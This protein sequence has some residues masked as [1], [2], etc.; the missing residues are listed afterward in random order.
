MSKEFQLKESDVK[1]TAV[2]SQGPGGQHVNKVSSAI[3]LR[4]D[5]LASG[6]SDSIKQRIL[7]SG[8]SRITK[9]G[10]LVMKVQESRSQDMNRLLAWSRLD[11]WVTSYSKEERIRRA[12]RPK[13]GAIE[14]RLKQKKQRSA[15]KSSRGFIEP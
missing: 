14:K 9:D 13:R 8:D 5:I 1:L 2:R 3:H 6:L 11:E 4:F 7:A 12:T 10:V 15:L